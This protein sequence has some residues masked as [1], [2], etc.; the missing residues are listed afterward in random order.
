MSTGI[1]PEQRRF[2]RLRALTQV[3]RALTYTTSIE[4][5][6]DLAL[7]HAAELVD[8]DKAV[9]MLMDP[10][11]LLAVRATYGVEAERF[12]RVHE[13]FDETLVR[14]LQD[15]LGYPSQECFLSVPLVSHGQVTGLL[16]AVRSR[17][18][19]ITKDDEWLLSALADQASVAL[20]NARLMEVAARERDERDRAAEA[21]DRA[22]ATLSHELRSPLNAIQSYSSL[23]LD[24][25]LDPLTERQRE[26]ISRIRMSGE[27]L[28]AVIENVLEMAQIHAG[29][30]KTTIQTVPVDPV[31]SEA[32]QLLQHSAAEKGQDVRTHGMDDVVVRADRDRLRQALVNLIGNAIK[33]TPEGGTIEVELTAVEREG[34]QLAAMAVIDDGRGIAPS[35]L[36]TIFEPY[37]RG[38]AEGHEGGL[39]L[40]LTISRELV[41][42]MGGDIEVESAPGHG[43]T[44]TVLLPIAAETPSR[45]RWRSRPREG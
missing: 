27:H 20:E 42:Q 30:L 43:S 35:V 34:R 44:F 16:G 1:A 6:L 17:G 9:L 25:V 10:N 12:A 15:L 37:Q 38:D 32:L 14:R 21:Q 36:E 7:Q 33:Y 29:T 45:A 41:R 5:V 8:A 19:P 31:V 23:L 2:E 11:G 13:A 3:S 28:L 24:G 40:G 39:G 4:E 26:S 22:R 18:E